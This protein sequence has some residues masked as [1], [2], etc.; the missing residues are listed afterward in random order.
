[1]EALNPNVDWERTW[2]RARLKGLSSD[3]STFLWRLLHQLLPTLNR[4]HRMTPNT[5]PNCKH[6]LEGVPEDILHAF[7]NCTYNSQ[8]SQSLLNTLSHYQPNINPSNILTLSFET[9]EDLELPIVW[10]VSNFLEE[11][12][13][14]RKEKK[15]CSLVRIRADLE[16]RVS[17]L[18]KTRFV[19]SSTIISQILSNL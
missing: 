3:Q 12:W 19:D 16:A 17:L 14:H 2:K 18:R 7:F 15:R 4:V 13:N 1:M 5:S 8:L 10:T 9:D 11:I 6:C